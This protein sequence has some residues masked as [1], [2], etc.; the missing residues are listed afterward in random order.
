[1]YSIISLAL[2]YPACAQEEYIATAPKSELG[3]RLSS[4]YKAV[5]AVRSYVSAA[6]TQSV[7]IL[8]HVFQIGSK[9]LPKFITVYC[10]KAPLF[11]EGKRSRIDPHG[12][13]IDVPVNTTSYITMQV[14]TLGDPSNVPYR[15]WVSSQ[16]DFDDHL[17]PITNVL[18]SGDGLKIKLVNAPKTITADG[19]TT[20]KVVVQVTNDAGAALSNIPCFIHWVVPGNKIGE[21]QMG[22]TT[23]EKGEF[24][25]IIPVS[26]EAGLGYTIIETAHTEEQY[27]YQYVNP[28][29]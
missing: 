17:C 26:K 28:K 19:I 22:A 23:N 20:S 27:I 6:E 10:D 25:F 29:N 7:P 24:T 16:N 4:D 3:W 5:L 2:I 8:L 12:Y 18:V 1:M 14:E 21:D 13:A 15:L 9:S 11:F